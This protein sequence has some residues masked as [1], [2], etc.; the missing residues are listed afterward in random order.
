MF[1]KDSN[2]P[3]KF[4]NFILVFNQNAKLPFGIFDLGFFKNED[5][6]LKIKNKIWNYCY[7]QNCR[8]F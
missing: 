5:S 8:M 6:L 1:S 4:A 7:G 3:S 2:L